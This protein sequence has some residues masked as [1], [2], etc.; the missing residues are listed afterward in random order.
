MTRR[1]RSERR[2][3]LRCR[4]FTGIQHARC[5]EG[6]RY[7]QEWRGHLPCLGESQA[8]RGYSPRTAEELASQEREAERRLALVSRGLS[9][10]CEQPL[11][12]SRVIPDGP[13]AGHGPRLC[14]ACNR[15]A[16]MV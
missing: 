5:E 4:H 8:C 16:F 2:R 7:K 11:D 1:E 3:R 10:C 12:T 13:R 6:L 14:S 9:A 15:L